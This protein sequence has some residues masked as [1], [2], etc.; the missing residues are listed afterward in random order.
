MAKSSREVI[1]ALRDDRWF[2][3][4]QTGSHLHLKHPAKRGKVTVPHPTKTLPLGTL[5]SIERQSGVETDLVD[6]IGM[7]AKKLH[8]PAVIDKDADSD[9]GVA[10]PDFPGCVS[11]GTTLDEA[12]LGA[13]EALAGHVAAMVADADPLPEPTPLEAVAANR[14]AS[15][16]AITLVA[17]TLPG[18]MQRVNI[19]MDEGLLDEIDAVA[20]NRSRFLAD[21]ARAELG[22]PAGGLA[23]GGEAQ[24]PIT[25]LE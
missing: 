19:T 15:T 1:R 6:D 10:F 25:Y 17:V 14:D 3:V 4:G 9:F 18:K 22:A 23:A 24:L 13:H 7:A 16:V 20:D 5:K 11:A 2:I 8:Y 21:A 12:V